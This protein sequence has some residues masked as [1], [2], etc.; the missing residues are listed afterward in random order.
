VKREAE[1]LGEGARLVVVEASGGADML[2]LA[3]D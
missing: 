1:L 3:A 2:G